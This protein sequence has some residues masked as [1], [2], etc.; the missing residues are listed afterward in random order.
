MRSLKAILFDFDGTL[1]SSVDMYV[2]IFI[3][4]LAEQ[5]VTPGSRAE[6]R[7]MAF[8]PLDQIFEKLA[9]VLDVNKF[10]ESF[11]TKELALNHSDNL[12][13]I[14]EVPVLLNFLR[15]QKIKAGIVSSKIRKPIEDLLH[16]YELA[17]YFDIIVGRDDVE[18]PK[19]SPEPVFY[20]C[21]QLAVKPSETLF[22]GDSLL[23]LTAA[24]EA[25]STFVGVLTGACTR[26]ELA[27]NKA[28]YIFTH[29]GEVAELVRHLQN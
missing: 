1:V 12:P 7:Y 6:I 25:G 27:R 21:E 20:A 13:L 11:L 3:E 23:D 16:D 2:D 14:E 8:T 15:K 5:G 17:K 10:R 28:D 19:P 18:S 26:E 29:V 4:C 9:T 22:V 24:K